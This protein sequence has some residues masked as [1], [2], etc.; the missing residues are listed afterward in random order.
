MIHSYGDNEFKT[1][2]VNL[3]LWRNYNI[4]SLSAPNK[5]GNKFINVLQRGSLFPKNLYEKIKCNDV[6][7]IYDHIR[8]VPFPRK[9]KKLSWCISCCAYLAHA[10]FFHIKFRTLF[11]NFWWGGGLRQNLIV[12]F[13]SKLLFT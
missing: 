11:C 5:S 12:C 6:S 7:V 10:E 13:F 1:D 8:A 2:S 3:F 4:V 9:R